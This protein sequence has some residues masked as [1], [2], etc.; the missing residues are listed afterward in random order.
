MEFEATEKLYADYQLV[1]T[2]PGGHSSLPKP[3]NAIYH[4]ADALAALQKSQFPFELNSVT[5]GYFEQMAKIEPAET[6]ADMRAILADAARSARPSRGCRRI[7]ATTR[8]CA[9]PASRPC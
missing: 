7:R 8:P 5:R 4:V 3:D 2:N 9:P 6:A 1:A